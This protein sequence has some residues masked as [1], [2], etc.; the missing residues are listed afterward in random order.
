MNRSEALRR[1]SDAPVGHL[2]TV[3][4]DGRPHVVVV[5]F[6][7]V[8]GRI[9]TA[10]DQKPKTTHRLQRLVNLG[11]DPNVSFLADHY[12][13]DWSRLWWV[14]V[15]GMATIWTDGEAYERAVDAL[16]AKYHQYVEDRP[17][18]PVIAVQCDHITSWASTP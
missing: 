9:V 13:S 5:T 3:R 15:D 10:V 8:D 14:R 16:A 1:L 7:S 4:P 11:N 6:T 18:G 12:D 17:S 2:A